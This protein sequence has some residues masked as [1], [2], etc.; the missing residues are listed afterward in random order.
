M[1]MTI[2]EIVEAVRSRY[3]RYGEHLQ[4]GCDDAE[5]E[6]LKVDV[7]NRYSINLPE[8]YLDL[9]RQV[10]GFGHDGYG[11][12]A[13]KP[14][15]YSPEDEYPVKDGIVEANEGMKL[16]GVAIPNGLCF[17]Y[18]DDDVFGLDLSTG[19]FRQYDV[20]RKPLKDF[21]S[22][23]DMFRFMFERRI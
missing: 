11:I 15:Y 13:S 14:A 22:F 4:P 6:R 2:H 18:G 7:H 16:D 21:G 9:L 1:K 17:G 23:E 20:Y 3:Q 12:Y 19:V 10:N 8:I 5:I